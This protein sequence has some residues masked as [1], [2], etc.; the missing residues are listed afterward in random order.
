MPLAERWVASSDAQDAISVLTKDHERIRRMFMSFEKLTRRNGNDDRKN[1]LFQQIWMETAIHAQVEDEI[2][3]PAL[4]EATDDHDLLD[5]ADI[6]HASFNE[7]FEQLESMGVDNEHYD[8]KV[9][10]LGEYISYHFKA[11]QDAMFRKIKMA[12]IDTLVLGGRIVHRRKELQS[13]RRRSV[14]VFM[15]TPASRAQESG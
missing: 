9:M 5:E 12:G 2:F 1:R 8:V 15:N 7:V 6:E 4:R 13:S 3:Y 14:G 11:E 10:V